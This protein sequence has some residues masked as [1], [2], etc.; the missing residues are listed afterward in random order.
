MN[1]HTKEQFEEFMSQLK[2]TNTTLDFYCDFEKIQNNV[3][4]ISSACKST[5]LFDRSERYGRSN[6][7]TLD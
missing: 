2:E 6:S 7:S 3:E 5:E 1:A 4:S